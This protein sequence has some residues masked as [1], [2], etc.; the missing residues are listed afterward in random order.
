MATLELEG[1]ELYYEVDG[2]GVDVL[3]IHG[4]ALDARMWD[5]QVAGLRDIARVIRYDARGFGRSSRDP[6]VVYTHAA[7][8]WALLDHLDVGRAVVVGLSMGGRIAL[9]TVLMAP[10][11][12]H[13]LA[14]LDAVLDG[15]AWDPATERDMAAVGAALESG[16][17]PAANA[18]WLSHGFFAPASRDPRLVA[19]LTAMV[20]EGP[21]LCWTG[22]DPHG[23]HPKAIDE[24]S[25]IS[26]PTV[27]IAGELDVACF[28]E[29]SE[30]LASRIPGARTLVIP[31][32]GHMVNMEAPDAVTAA[33]RELI[34]AV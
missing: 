30:V 14:L 16:G 24:L 12:V 33:L 18:A 15:V 20:A 29:M 9:E 23:P 7:D 6:D 32:A 1:T 26:V 4:L 17:V 5:E 3:L 19:R 13:A 11:R 34:I 8:A 21:G 27:V 28:R 10:T 2:D 22:P 31:D 25:R